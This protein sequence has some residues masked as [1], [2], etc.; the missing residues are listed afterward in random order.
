MDV[1]SFLN[2]ENC[3]ARDISLQQ[4]RF[5]FCCARFTKLQT[6]VDT[7][8]KRL[9]KLDRAYSAGGGLGFGLNI[10]TTSGLH[11]GG[12]GNNLNLTFKGSGSTQP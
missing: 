5:E 11:P 6:S 10:V 1:L 2:I 9:A 3:D 12:G 4:C 7:C 8:W